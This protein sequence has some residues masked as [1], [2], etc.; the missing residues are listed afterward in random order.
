MRP[1]DRPTQARP[2]SNAGIY[3]GDGRNALVHEVDCLAPE[4]RLEAVDEVAAHFLADVDGPLAD[5]AIE[6][7]RALD[8]GGA[9]SLAAD[10]LDQWDHVRGIE[11]MA[12]DAALGVPATHGD[13]GDEN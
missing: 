2:I 10:H 5:L 13:V 7:H 12:D 4:G 9:G 3:I 8:H 1:H 11:G 6:R